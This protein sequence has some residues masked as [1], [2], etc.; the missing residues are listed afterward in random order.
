MVQQW[1]TPDRSVDGAAFAAAATI[2]DQD[3]GGGRATGPGV[4]WSLADAFSQLA[5]ARSAVGQKQSQILIAHLDTGYDP[6]QTTAP[7]NVQVNLQKNYVDAAFPDDAQDRVPD[8]QPF[9]NRGHG[10]GTLS[11]LAGN[12]LPAGSPGWG[13]W[14]DYIGGA[15][16]A[17]IIPIRIADWVVRLSTSTMIKGIDHARQC[18]AN[19]LSMSMGGIAS[20]ALADAVNLAYEAGVFMVTAAGNNYADV[21]TPKTIVFPARFQ[22]V[23]AACGV[24]ADGRAYAGL[25]VGTMQGNYGPS[26]KMDTALG[27]YTPN[28]PWARIGGRDIVDMDGA[29]TSA[30][31]PQIAA[32][33][34]LWL[35]MHWDAVKS[36]PE[37]WM[38]IES[39]RNALFSSAA[40]TTAKMSAD[41]TR[42]KLGRGVMQAAAAL[43]IEPLSVQQLVGSKQP[44]AKSTWPWLDLIFGHGGVS[45]AADLGNSDAHRLMFALELTQMAQRVPAVEAAISN[46][47]APAG[48]VSG[49][50]RRSY[51]EAA[52]DHGDPSQALRKVLEA[53]MGRTQASSGSAGTTVSATSGASAA[54]TATTVKRKVRKA[55]TPERRLRIFALDPSIGNRLASCSVNETVLTLPWDDTPE[56]PLLPGPVG[57]Y[58]EVIDVDPASRKVYEPVNLND[59]FLLAQ[60]GWA[61]SEGNPQ[62]HQQMV[63]AVSMATIRHFERALG[64][65]MLWANHKV[66]KPGGPPG[67]ID[68]QEVRRLRIYPHALRTANAYYSPDKV[69]LLFGYFPAASRDSDATAPGSM[70]FACLSSDIIA[71]EMSHALLDGLQRH[72]QEASNPDVPAFHEGF[73]DIVALLQHFSMT[74]LVRFEIARARGDLSAAGLLGGLAQQFGEGMSR[75]APLR[76]YLPVVGAP[77]YADTEDAHARGS[78]LVFAVYEAFLGIVARRTADLIRIATGGTGI[79]PDGA[80]HPDLV[81]RLTIETC[82]SAGHMLHACI[83]ALDYCPSV[84]ITFGDYLRALITADLDFVEDDAWHYRVAIVEAFR[85]RGILPRDVRTISQESLA[86]NSPED[87]TPGWLASCLKGLDLQWNQDTDRSLLFARN[88]NNTKVMHQNLCAV[89]AARPELYAEFGLLP[90]IPRFD[91]NG[92]VLHRPEPGRSTF[93]VF[94]VRPTHRVSPDGSIRTDVIAVIEQRRPVPLDGVDTANG[95][96]W[97]RGGATLIIDSREDRMAIRYAVIKNCGSTTRLERQRKT[98]SG[99]FDSPLRGMYFG[100]STREPFAALHALDRE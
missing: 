37:P 6:A 29:G 9:T 28:V 45:L 79:L 62:F 81:E 100:A 73:A 5:S 50:D 7:A 46:P 74:E 82:K 4:G 12:R 2:R 25:G 34:A 80:L 19:V 49:K 63:Y 59:P 64:R 51:L 47:E 44:P 32:S 78:I 77:R 30:A 21:P 65:R 87:S 96:F 98:A 70:V 42:E 56:S 76:N 31:T 38:R 52:L 67:A 27:A 54:R 36:Y 84:D 20:H 89:F 11:L 91:E 17:G 53:L 83:R 41:E 18:N 90:D 72:F 97:F 10:T 22:R 15:P 75:S 68:V 69:A 16:L 39:V 1:L 60:D 26:A 85:N 99:V 40:K 58:L 71:H 93:N 8:G 43:A 86:W 14:N 92:Q 3:S 33:A 24:M 88:E 57:E 55:P 61:P 35:G 94:S 66:P 23:L 95:W 13:S 48:Q